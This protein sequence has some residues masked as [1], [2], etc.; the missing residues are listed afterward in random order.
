MGGFDALGSNTTGGCNIAL[1]G[2]AL[3]DANANHNI[4]LG[5]SAGANLTSGCHNV[6][7]GNVAGG[8]AAVTGNDNIAG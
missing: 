6:F 8:G 7:L 2:N 4:A 3:E 5:Q 1:G